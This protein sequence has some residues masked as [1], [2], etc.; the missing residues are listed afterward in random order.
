MSWACLVFDCPICQ[1]LKSDLFRYQKLNVPYL[2]SFWRST[3][4]PSSSSFAS[5][6]TN[7]IQFLGDVQHQDK[8][9]FSGIFMG[10]ASK[11]ANFRVINGFLDEQGRLQGSTQIKF[12]GSVYFTDVTGEEIVQKVNV[13]FKVGI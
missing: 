3:P 12:T 5:P 10:N 9:L 7:G 2:D 4:R 6:P 1:C 8:D 11:R 13:E